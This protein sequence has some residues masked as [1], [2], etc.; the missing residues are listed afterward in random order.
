MEQSIQ[1][2]RNMIGDVQTTTLLKHTFSYGL[3]LTLVPTTNL[4]GNVSVSNGLC[5]LSVGNVA[6][7]VCILTSSKQM[8][9]S[10]HIASRFSGYF[11]PSGNTVQLCG[12]GSTSEGFFFGSHGTGSVGIVTRS[13]GR[14]HIYKLQISS[15]CTVSGIL[16]LTLDSVSYTIPLTTGDST[17]S[18]ISKIQALVFEGLRTV[19]SGNTIYFF[20]IL[21][22]TLDGT[23]T[24]DPGTTGVTTILNEYPG[25]PPNET[26]VASSDWNIDP[27]NDSEELPNIVFSKGNQF[28]ILAHWNGYGNVVFSI[29]NPT[30]GKFLPVHYVNFTNTR[31]TPFL[32]Y[33]NT[34]LYFQVSNNQQG[35]ES[36]FQVLESSLIA[37]DA[38]KYQKEDLLSTSGLFKTPTFVYGSN[39][40]VLSVQVAPVFHSVENKS[41]ITIQTVAITTRTAEPVFLF[42]TKRATLS[43]PG[44][45][46]ILFQPIPSSC[47]LSCTQSNI[48]VSQGDVIFQTP[49]LVGDHSTIINVENL[50]ITLTPAET[51]TVSTSL[52]VNTTIHNFS[53]FTTLT[54]KES[55]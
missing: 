34:P 13:G 29:Q 1:F 47:A 10:T 33:V 40:H 45:P 52:A 6:N 14:S 24:I 54:W 3:P 23:S 17:T 19:V 16:T 25:T 48:M 31:T 35:L 12:I 39:A 37:L 8:F 51:L 22:T 53:F 26:F 49:F 44:D 30:T 2:F 11:D 55:S 41:Q 4:T 20:S 18:I 21:C 27:V 50:N 42:L 15:S 9:E 7:S 28:Q 36:S 43:D 38:T 46:G 5:S 32:R